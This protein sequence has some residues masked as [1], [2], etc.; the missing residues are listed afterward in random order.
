MHA[1]MLYREPRF[2]QAISHPEKRAAPRYVFGTWLARIE[3]TRRYS[4]VSLGTVWPSVHAA[5]E[6]GVNFENGY[7]A[8]RFE[9]RV[10]RPVLDQGRLRGPISSGIHARCWTGFRTGDLDAHLQM[11]CARF[12]ATPAA[13][14]SWR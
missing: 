9:F 5:V 13:C 11:S 14:I 3:L 4:S 6:R 2:R 1:A 12:T 8:G 7:R 10:R